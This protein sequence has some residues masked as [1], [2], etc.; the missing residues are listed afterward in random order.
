V[1]EWRIEAVFRFPVDFVLVDEQRNFLQQAERRSR[2]PTESAVI[3]DRE[4][5]IT[6]TQL[7]NVDPDGRYE[8]A[9]ALFKLDAEDA[10]SAI[11]RATTIIEDLVETF[12]FQSQ[13]LVPVVQFEALDVTPPVALGDEREGVLFPY[14]HGLPLPKFRGSNQLGGVATQLVPTLMQLNVP[15]SRVDAALGWHLKAMASPFIAEQYMLN[16]I[17]LEILWRRS[18]IS[19]ETNYVAQCGHTIEN[20]PICGGTTARE[21]RG[22]SIRKYLVDEGQ[23]DESSVRR[24]WRVRQMFHGDVAFDSD[25]MAELPTLIQMLRAVV[26]GQLKHALGFS[27]DALPFV[28]AGNVAVAPEF[29]LGMRRRV[30]A[31]DL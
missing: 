28:T 4:L 18:D 10:D 9:S 1:A 6:P 20:C 7:Q 3:G 12:S 14:P 17:A 23:L 16:W 21:V 25:E 8:L 24:M 15:D 2:V 30:R 26:V 27:D 22:A 13:Q 29:A 31:K 11:V 5:R 19:V